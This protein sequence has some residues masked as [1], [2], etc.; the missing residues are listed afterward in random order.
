MKLTY[1]AMNLFYG[2]LLS[3][4]KHGNLILNILGKETSLAAF[5]I[6]LRCHRKV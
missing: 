3:E 1:G 5:D 6:P 4:Y 2:L